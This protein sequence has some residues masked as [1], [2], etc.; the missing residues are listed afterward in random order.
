MN[1]KLIIFDLD[2]TL[3]DSKDIHF[4]SLN[5]ALYEINENL[6]ISESDQK[7]I[8]EGLPTIEKLKI[9]SKNHNLDNNFYENVWKLKQKY[10]IEMFK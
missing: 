6:V 8:Y 3:V 10:T 7:N 9:L 2:G 5:K 4:Q 1:K